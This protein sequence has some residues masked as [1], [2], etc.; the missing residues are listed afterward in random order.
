[1]NE[2]IIGGWLPNLLEQ[3]HLLTVLLSERLPE[4][5]PERLLEHLPKAFVEPH[6]KIFTKMC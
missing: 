2:N 3:K 1:V 4:R 6:P 5:L